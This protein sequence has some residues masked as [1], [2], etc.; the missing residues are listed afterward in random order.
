MADNQDS[1][2]SA[3]APQTHRVFV[4]GTLR[5]GFSNHALLARSK[6]AGE[7]ATL[8]TYWMITTGPFPV[9]LDDV[10][11]D[12][13][14]APLAVAGEIYHVDDATLAQLDRLEREGIAYDRKVT[15]VFEAGHKVEAHIYVGVADYWHPRGLPAWTVQNERDELNW[16][17]S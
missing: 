6:F 3:A 5:R 14:V 12:F 1:T 11:A 16:S 4:Y 13:G 7:A 8:R 2:P 17:P 9:L 15:E 10:P